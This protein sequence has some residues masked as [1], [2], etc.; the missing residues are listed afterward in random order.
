MRGFIEIPATERTFEFSINV[1]HIK[2][3]VNQKEGSKIDFIDGTKQFVDL[4]YNQVM[5]LIQKAIDGTN[6]NDSVYNN[7]DTTFIA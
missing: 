2:M 6:S 5:I 7:P 3:V 4:T 1:R